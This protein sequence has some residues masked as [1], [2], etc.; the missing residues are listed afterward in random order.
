MELR[1]ENSELNDNFDV[2][3]RFGVGKVAIAGEL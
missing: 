3:F 2:C 1:R